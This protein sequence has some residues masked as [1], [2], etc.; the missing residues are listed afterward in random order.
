MYHD[1][2]KYAVQA[3]EAIME[4]YTP[5]ELPPKGC[6]FYHQGVFLSGMERLYELIGDKKYFRYIKEYVDYVLGPNGE[7]YGFCHELGL[8]EESRFKGKE[9]T[10]L[11]CKQPAI[12]LYKLYDETGDGKYM[13]AL[14]TIGESMYYWPVN[15]Y[16]G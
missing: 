9:L 1:A 12:L 6:F 4:T 13:R 15:E 8:R 14:K 10:L 5:Q 7:V 2:I 3:C 16:G 11:D